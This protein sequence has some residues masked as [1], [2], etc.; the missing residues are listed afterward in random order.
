MTGVLTRRQLQ[1]LDKHL[2]KFTHLA[3]KD[4]DRELSRVFD[5]IGVPRGVRGQVREYARIRLREIREK[6]EERRKKRY[7][8]QDRVTT[9][10]YSITLQE[11]KSRMHD[12]TLLKIAAREIARRDIEGPEAAEYP[13]RV[14][15]Y[16]HKVWLLEA[17]GIREYTTT[18]RWSRSARWLFGR[19]DQGYWAVRVPRTISTVQEGLEWLKPAA[20]QKAEREGR[21]VARQ[22]DVYVVELKTAI[23]NVNDLPESHEYD[24]KK[25]AIVHEGHHPLVIPP[26]VR[27]FR[28]YRQGQIAPG[29]GRMYAD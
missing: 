5:K 22:G 11:L 29:G 7:G 16:S 13:T 3:V 25:R 2:A 23:I 20:V 18:E 10:G 14:L 24:D 12:R 1:V 27:G 8:A 21:W 17:W 28:V 15:A 6:Q 4:A 26:H 19:D 9:A